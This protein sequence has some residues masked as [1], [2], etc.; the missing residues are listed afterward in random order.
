MVTIK[1]AD[2]KVCDSIRQDL[3]SLEK[4]TFEDIV[5]A[6]L[7][8]ISLFGVFYFL[9]LTAGVF[10]DNKLKG[11]LYMAACLVS[12]NVFIRSVTKIEK[13]I[14]KRNCLKGLEYQMILMSDI[15]AITEQTDYSP[16][17][18]SLGNDPE[19][20]T[21]LI[22]KRNAD[23]PEVFRIMPELI[24]DAGNGDK[25]VDFTKMS[26]LYDFIIKK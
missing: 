17:D 7:T 8:V 1:F 10:A 5:N 22:V 11:F 20:E 18:M 24:S 25:I 14:T 26:D 16:E 23:K 6:A 3:A 9:I 21:V 15:H 4:N 13:A 12:G 2:E 19:N